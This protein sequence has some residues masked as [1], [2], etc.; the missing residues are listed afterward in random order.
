MP[1]LPPGRYCLT[2]VV[3]TRAVRLLGASVTESRTRVDIDEHGEAT[4]QTT[5]I[6]AS[7]R[8]YVARPLAK[9]YEHIP[10]QRYRF[11]VDGDAVVADPGP[12]SLVL[13]ME[14]VV[15]RVGRFV[16]DVESHGHSRY[17]GR[18]TKRGAAGDVVVIEQRQRVLTG[19]PIRLD[20]SPAVDVATFVLEP[21]A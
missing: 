9:A 17:V 4:S 8:G 1:S 2:V 16:V 12:L 5:S 14:V 6:T 21:E 20:D 10:L 13:A 11:D 19:L 3:K 18:R 15:S 7:G